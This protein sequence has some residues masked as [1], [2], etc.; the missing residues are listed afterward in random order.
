MSTQATSIGYLLSTPRNHTCT[1]LADHLPRVS[2]DQANRFLRNG[3]SCVSPLR[4]LALPL[5]N[6]PPEAFL[7]VY[8]RG[9]DKRDSRFIDLAQR[10]YPGTPHGLP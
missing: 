1:Q 5:P 9:Q 3:S 4:A 7:L 6:D 8:D 10:Q 2:H